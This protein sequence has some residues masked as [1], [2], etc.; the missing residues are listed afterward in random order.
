[1]IAIANTSVTLRSQP[2]KGSDN[3][4]GVYGNEALK[5]IAR[6][7]AATWL[8]VIAPDAPGGMAWVLAAAFTLQGDITQLP[9]AIFPKDSKVP[10]L[11]P[12]VI[13]IIPGGTP[14]P[15]NPPAPGAITATVNQRARV[16]VGPGLGYMELG[17]LEP[18]TVIVL[19]GRIKANAWIQIEYPSGLDGRAWLA[20]ELVNYTGEYNVLPL[21]NQIATPVTGD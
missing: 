19:T 8:Y 16:R 20:G 21:Y 14:L 4:G 13:L 6:N 12:P 2:N 9:I 17:V 5:V 18:G 10:I 1:M 7:I 11:H 15:L 3:V